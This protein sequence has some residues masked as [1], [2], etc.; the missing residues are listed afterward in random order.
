MSEDFYL[1]LPSHSCLNEFPNNRNNNFKIRLPHQI[2]L[3]GSGWQV[4]LTAISLPDI[5]LNLGRYKEIVEPL[6]RI[7]WFQMQDRT[8][9]VHQSSNVRTQT[10]EITFPDIC[11]Y[12]NIHNGVDFFKALIIRYEQKRKEHL[13]TGWDTLTTKDKVLYPIF[14]WEGEDLILD[15]SMLDLEIVKLRDIYRSTFEISFDKHIGVDFGWVSAKKDDTPILGPNIQMEYRQVSLEDDPKFIIENGTLGITLGSRGKIK[16]IIKD[17]IIKERR[18]RIESKVP[19]PFGTDDVEPKTDRNTTPPTDR[20]WRVT[21]KKK[22]EENRV[23]LSCT[24]NWRFINIK[25]AFDD[26]VG[27]TNRTLYIYSDAGGGTVVGNRMTDLLREV[28]FKSDGLGSQYFEPIYIQYIPV[29]KQ[30]LDIIEV[31]VAETTGELTRFGEGNTIL[32]LHFRK[33]P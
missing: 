7:K 15:N 23:H 26:L 4:G 25:S 27:G 3:E 12:G 10:T 6:L 8:K 18:L 17:G 22:S 11:H 28:R 29:R 5:N 24:C 16:D 32:T 9:S 2:R 30:V 33:A 13:P 19:E 21:N 20:F 1:S 14:R 31:N